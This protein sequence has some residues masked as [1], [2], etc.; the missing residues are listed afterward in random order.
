LTKL[1]AEFTKY[2]EVALKCDAIDF[3]RSNRAKN[4]YERV[5]LE[6]IDELKVAD[7]VLCKNIKLDIIGNV[8]LCFIGKNGVG[9]STLIK[10]I[11]LKLKDR[12]DI[13]VGYM[14]Q[15]YDDILS[16]LSRAIIDTDCLFLTYEH[17]YILPFIH[18]SNSGRTFSHSDFPYLTPVKSLWDLASPYYIEIT[19]YTYEF[20]SKI[21]KIP[22]TGTSN[23]NILDVD[24]MHFV[25]KIKINNICI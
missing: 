13:K 7:K 12:D 21:L 9:K 22:V 1:Q 5:S 3:Y 14:P 17:S 4:K 11:Y 10:E 2:M 18:F 24:H 8:H 16:N 6:D 19:D 25:H 15:M 23:F 20:I